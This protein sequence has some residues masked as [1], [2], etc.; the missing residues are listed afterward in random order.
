MPRI[1][2]FRLGQSVEEVAPPTLAS[3]SPSLT[4]TGLQ[5][6]VDNLR[7]DVHLSEKFVTEMRAQ[8]ALMTASPSPLIVVEEW[9]N[10]AVI[11]A[12]LARVADV[13]FEQA[14]ST[15]EEW[16]ERRRP[17]RTGQPVPSRDIALGLLD[18][19]T[20]PARAAA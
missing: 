9:A 3:Y 16:L 4:L 2:L 5:L 17:P 13:P 12:A 10:P 1:P 6:G 15:V 7:H 18:E 14:A 19:L 20:S 11:A 8:I